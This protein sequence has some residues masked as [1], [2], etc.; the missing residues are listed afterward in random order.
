[1]AK[2]GRKGNHH[3]G[4]SAVLGIALVCIALSCERFLQETD[5]LGP[6]ISRW[7]EYWLDGGR[8]DSRFKVVKIPSSFDGTAQLAYFHAAQVPEAP[9]V[10]SLH[11][12]SGTYEQKDA[13]AEMVVARGWGYLR[14]N[15]RGP[16]RTR[17]AC[18]SAAVLADID[19]AIRFAMEN[20]N[21]HPEKV[22]VVGASG[23]GY[24]ALGYYLR[25]REKVR[26][27]I[28]WNPITDLKSW[29]AESL[30]RNP[31]FVKDIDLCAGGQFAE[32]SPLSMVKVSEHRARLEIFAG[33]DDGHEGSVPISHSLHFYNRIAAPH[34]RLS[35]VD[36]E[37][38]L[39]RDVQSIQGEIGGREIYFSRDSDDVAMTIFD[40]GHEML[41]EH[42]VS[43]IEQLSDRPE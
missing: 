1:M 4:H 2:K 28:V 3:L 22:F 10:I 43:R 16:N 32:R 26:A 29:R 19:D 8:W 30:L 34:H 18:L 24:A 12:W 14:P 36:V 40:G 37:R 23:G 5:W 31:E 35:S 42:T 25:A 38:Y 11:T 21:A 27:F 15:F 13:L 33:L 17:D 39:A 9:V 20:G 7:Q 6:T 41:Y